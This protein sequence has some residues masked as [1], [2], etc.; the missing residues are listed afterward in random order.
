MKEDPFIEMLEDLSEGI[1]RKIKYPNF[2]QRDSTKTTLKRS[3]INIIN[4]NLRIAAIVLVFALT[5]GVIAM[6]S[7]V[8]DNGIID[9]GLDKAE[10]EGKVNYPTSFAIDQNIKVAV[11]GAVS[12]TSRTVI[13]IDVS[14]KLSGNGIPELKGIQLLDDQ[15]KEYQIDHYGSGS[16][17]GLKK[18]SDKTALEFKG[19]PTKDSILTLKLASVNHVDGKWEIKFPITV[20]ASKEFVIDSK[21][22]NSS[23]S[24]EAKKIKFSLTQTEIS[25]TF[26]S[27]NWIN[28]A[29]LSNGI[30][31]LEWTSGDRHFQK[32]KLVFP[33][34]D[35][36][37]KMSL[38]ITLNDSNKTILLIPIL[39]KIE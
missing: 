37:N 4:F 30:N 39:L 26:V 2:D 31:E 36:T 18:S 35:Q 9:L 15:G 17:D 21:I 5:T 34:I 29:T 7:H 33:P 25:G 23:T 3:G 27:N 12:D 6:N 24:F 16:Y 22:E 13:Q 14:N 19:G 20:Y 1:K 11:I 10:N 38:T 8:F 32:V 28:K